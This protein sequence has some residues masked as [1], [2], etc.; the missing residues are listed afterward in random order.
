MYDACGEQ[1]GKSYRCVYVLIFLVQ[2]SARVILGS[3]NTKVKHEQ[4]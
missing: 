4:N 1:R 2:I 3:E